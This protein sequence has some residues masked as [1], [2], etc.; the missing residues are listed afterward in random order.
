VDNDDC[1][2]CMH[3]INVMHRALKPGKDRGV[4]FLVGGKRTLKIGDTMSSVIVPFM[5]LET[6]EDYDKLDELIEKIWDFWCD[7]GMEHERVGEFIARVGMS[8]FLDGIGIEPDARM[9]MQPRTS[10]YI[11][12]EELAPARLEGEE[13]HAPPVWNRESE[14]TE[15]AE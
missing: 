13:N 7:N 14:A 5:K 11:K 12:F 6:E 9:V 8:T 2:R 15:A 10:P 4:T 3:C 1:V